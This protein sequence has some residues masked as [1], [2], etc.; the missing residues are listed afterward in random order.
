MIGFSPQWLARYSLRALGLDL[1][2]YRAQGSGRVQ[3]SGCGKP[4]V[5]LHP[6]KK[7][8]A[9]AGCGW[10]G[11]EVC[12]VPCVQGGL[13][14]LGL[15]RTELVECA[16]G[17]KMATCGYNK[18][19]K[20]L[21]SGAC[22]GAG[23]G[24]LWPALSP[25]PSHLRQPPLLWLHLTRQGQDG[26]SMHCLREDPQ[27][28]PAPCCMAVVLTRAAPSCAAG[29]APGLLRLHGR[30]LPGGLCRHAGPSG[31]AACPQWGEVGGRVHATHTSAL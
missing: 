31:G 13:V 3:R 10:V 24:V 30:P 12:V 27:G 26:C 2:Q 21:T 15:S 28:V 18:R 14:P 1:D 6:S 11:R 7:V 29:G 4:Q 5:F 25:L 9:S 20:W 23:G 19:L 22:T 16:R 8:W 17:L